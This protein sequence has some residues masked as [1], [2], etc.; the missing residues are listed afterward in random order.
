MKR[1]LL[2]ILVSFTSYGANFKYVLENEKSKMSINGTSFLH[3]WE[4]KVGNLSGEGSFQFKK[5]KLIGIKDFY[6]KVETLSIKSGTESLDEKTY[7]A[8]RGNN[9]PVIRATI[10]NIE[11]F[12]EQVN[13]TIDIFVGGVT[14]TEPFFVKITSENS[15]SLMIVGEKKLSMKSFQIE[16]PS[17]MFFKAGDEVTVSF[18]LYL[19]IKEGQEK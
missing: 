5:D 13:G 3:N 7:E 2:L 12:G 18:S 9:Y 10:K 11:K 15:K 19:K 8:L 16:P 6:L 17:V 4:T 1:I 14:Q